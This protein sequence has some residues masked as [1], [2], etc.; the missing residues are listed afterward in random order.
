MKISEQTINTFYVFLLIILIA[1][2]CI[3]RAEHV[4]RTKLTKHQIQLLDKNIEV[5]KENIVA[6]EKVEIAQKY[7]NVL[8]EYYIKNR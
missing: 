5:R 6:L 3:T 1:D 4:E 8:L 7:T 2:M